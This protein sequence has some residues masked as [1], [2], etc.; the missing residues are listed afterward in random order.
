MSCNR[1]RL[2]SFFCHLCY[3]EAL[4]I[5]RDATL[6]PD[7]QFSFSLSP[8]WC[9]YLTYLWSR[10]GAKRGEKRFSN[11]PWP[12]IT[13]SQQWLSRYLFR[14]SSLHFLHSSDNHA[15]VRSSSVF[16]SEIHLLLQLWFV[17]DE[18]SRSMCSLVASGDHLDV[19]RPNQI[20]QRLWLWGERRWGEVRSHLSHRYVGLQLGWS[21]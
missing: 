4:W 11:T 17:E 18:T 19:R 1:T 14:W 13:S 2:F 16:S 20:T 7:Y 3:L 10:W 6:Q 15:D 12:M 9:V 8:V 5:N 21:K